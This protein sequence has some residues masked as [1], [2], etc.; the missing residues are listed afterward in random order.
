[1]VIDELLR[2]HLPIRQDVLRRWQQELR[3]EVIPQLDELAAIKA[4]AGKPTGMADKRRKAEQ[5]T[6]T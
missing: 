5:E 2:V 3:D 4:Q 1:M 6:T